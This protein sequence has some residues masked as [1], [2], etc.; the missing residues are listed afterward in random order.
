MVVKGA[1]QDR[2]QPDEGGDR[3]RGVDEPVPADEM[4]RGRLAPRPHPDRGKVMTAEEL[5]SGREFA[6]YK[7]IDGDGIP[8]RTYPGTH[9]ARGDVVTLLTRQVPGRGE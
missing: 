3:E 1:D 4:R 9:P 5:E 2:V 6:R 8:Y 7:D